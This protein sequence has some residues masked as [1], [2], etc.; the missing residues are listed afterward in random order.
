M[1]NYRAKCK[2]NIQSWISKFHEVASQGPLYICTCCDQLWYNCSVLCVDKL[3]QSNP[4]IDKYLGNKTSVDDIEW[5]CKTCHN[6]LVKNRIPPCA[7]VNGL[8]FPQKPAFFY[9]NE[10]EC[11]L[12]APRIAFQKLMQAPRGKQLK[13]HGNIVNVPAD[14]TNTVS[15]LPRLPSETGT[16]K[17]NLKR[18]LQYKSSAMSLNVRPH[19]VVEAALWL[20]SNSS[21]YKDEGIVLNQDWIIKYNE[22]ILQHENNSDN[23]CDQQS[24]TA[25]I[26]SNNVNVDS[27]K[28]DGED[29][30]SEDEVEIPAGVTDTMLTSTDFLEA[31]EHENILS[32]APAKGNRPLSVFRDKY[33]EE[34]AYPGIFLGQKRAENEEHMVKVHYSEICK[35]ELRRSDRRAAM[36]V[37]NIFYK[38]KKLQ[39]KI[40]L[41]QSQ[42]ALRKCKGNSRILNAGNL[43]QQGTLDSLIRR[44]EGFN[45]L[46]ALEVHLHILRKLKETFLQ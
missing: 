26:N 24:V 41:G 33:S 38:T 19:K 1:K 45:F 46:R 15:M 21:L 22:E 11:R 40:L 35:S 34:L 10:L 4:D 23:T 28:V 43:K 17:V 20:M 6:H 29:E 7:V 32:V 18:K 36:C 9:L 25:D 30:W 42:I 13:I 44:D 37:E 3:R 16:I 5:V 31:T 39:M 27:Q 12:L 2:N 14:V 8:V